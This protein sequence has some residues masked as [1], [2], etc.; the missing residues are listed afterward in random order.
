M[1]IVICLSAL[2]VLFLLDARRAAWERAS[3]VAARLAAAFASDMSH[4]FETL[5]LSLQAV[6]ENLKQPGIDQLRP[7]L[8]NLLLFDRSA[9]AR[10]LGSILGRQP[11][12][13]LA[14]AHAGPAQRRRP[15]LFPG[16]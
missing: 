9:T 11:A 16:A 1:L 5:D 14:H 15:R 6:V 12:L 13:R 4:N 2:S 7:E 8:R 10:H 3:D